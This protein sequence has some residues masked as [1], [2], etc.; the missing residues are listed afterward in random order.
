MNSEERIE[1]D[2]DLIRRLRDVDNDD[3]IDV[4][5]WEGKFIDSM[6]SPS[7]SFPL[8]ISQRKKVEDILEKYDK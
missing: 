6:L 5:E 3:F 4:T 7:L 2:R 8:S 1:E